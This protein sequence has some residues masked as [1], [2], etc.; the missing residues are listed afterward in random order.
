MLHPLESFIQSEEQDST[1]TYW[2]DPQLPRSRFV[3]AIAR[4]L[5]H[6]LTE[7]EGKMYGVLLVRTATGELRVLKAF[8]GLLNGQSVLPGWVPPI[9]G[10]EQVAI[11]EAQTLKQLDEIKEE[12]LQLQQIPERHQYLLLQQVFQSELESLAEIHRQRKADRDVRRED[13]NLDQLKLESQKDGI[14]KRKLK[15]QRDQVLQP[16]KQIIEQ[17]DAQIQTLKRRR[18]RLSQSLQSQMQSAYRITNFAGN[19]LSLEQLIQRGMPTGTGECCA[20]KLLHYAATHHLKAIALAEFWWGTSNRDKI[21]G[22]FYGACVDRCQPILGFLLSG[23]SPS[24]E[25][26]YEDKWLVIVNK[27]AGLLSVPGR[28]TQDCVLAR[29]PFPTWAVHRLDQDTSGVLAIAKDLDTYRHL[30]QQFEHR[31]VKKIYEAVLSSTLSQSEG[32]IELPLWSD[33]CDR[34]KQKVDPRGKASL[35]Q[36]RKIAP[37]RV[38]FVPLTGRTHQLRVHAAEGLGVPILGDRL[39]GA[40]AAGRLHLHARELQVNHPRSQQ[41]LRLRVDTPF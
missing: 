9:P 14:E 8:S 21:Q 39:Y 10:R 20:P 16:L 6:Q 34:P 13:T 30:S 22:E 17:A 11:A 1:P 35:T 4:G 18:K 32:M 37:N 29:L 33:P 19:S 28:S 40:G 41:D 26:L 38:E 27:P 31:Q 3:E 5:M 12:L 24:L 25:I 23:L 15:Q 2:Y 7:S 36:Y